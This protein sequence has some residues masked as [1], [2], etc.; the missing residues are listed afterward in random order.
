MINSKASQKP[1]DHEELITLDLLEMVEKNS[2]VT[3]RSL[4]A[5][6]NVAL[7]LA[8]SYI[9]RCAK[10]G[11]IKVQQA[12]SNRYAYYLTPSG[13]TEKGRLTAEYLKQSFD[14][15]RLAR[16]QSADLV[17]YC[18]NNGWARIALIGKSDLTEI[19]ILS[20]TELQIELVGII[21]EEAAIT[22]SSYMNLPVVS[23]FS[24]LN[25]VNATIITNMENPQKK[26]D[27]TIKFFPRDQV[28]NV[29]LL[30]INREV[31]NTSKST[32]AS[33]GV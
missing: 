13:F 33:V 6:L 3:Q 21:D 24:D 27:E 29:S 7:G 23:A 14:F 10:K 32:S 16:R 22:T 2:A 26:F 12:P 5:E 8:N 15:F 9:K 4:A 30:G 28:L 20:A 25:T 31:G 11:L 17:Q 18:A 19:T 1:L